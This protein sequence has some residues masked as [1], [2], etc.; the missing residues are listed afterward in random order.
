MLRLLTFGPLLAGLA[1]LCSSSPSLQAQELGDA[2]LDA[3]NIGRAGTSTVSGDSGVA[4]VQ[5]P[6]GMVRRAQSRLLLGVGIEDADLEYVST[7]ASSPTLTNRAAPTTLP[8]VAYHHGL[9]DGRWVLGVL[10]RSGSSTSSLPAPAFGQPADD[11]ERLF[12]H[13]YAGTA[14]ESTWRQLALGAA[15]RLGDSWGLG[16][17]VGLRDLEVREDRRIWAGFG[18]RDRLLGAERDLALS[19]VGRD[20]VNPSGSIGVL[21]APLAIPLEFAA[22]AEFQAGANLSSSSA[23][24]RSTNSSDF[25]RVE[26]NSASAQTSWNDRATLRGGMRY[27]GEQ[28]IVEAGIDM[29]LVQ[30]SSEELW[31]LTGLD[32]VDESTVR[33]SLT[34]APTLHSERSR[35][36][37]RGAVDY[38]AL[39]GF[40]WITGGYA[41]HAPST[42][43]NKRMP[44]YAKLGGHRLALGI[45]ANHE[46][47]SLSV[48]YSR[49][50]ARTR[51]IAD[52]DAQ[53]AI[54]PFEAGTG[55]ANA[56]SYRTASDQL[57]FS[58]EVAW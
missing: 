54:N 6:A 49:G 7:N 20:R 51:S 47:Y 50:F 53:Q 27:L 9:A 58:L 52:L 34:S 32:V 8:T 26:G 2:L 10:L 5:N 24:L 48:G 30:D 4:I 18:G 56:G 13:R 1:S 41:W 57:G 28:L 12:P 21:Y 42:S 35:M 39:A 40:L 37:I 25:P 19:I 14:Y 29:A 45:L 17:S 44:A 31:Q 43:Q 15:V 23:S 38:E 33:S 46:D 55:P 22:S 11:V 3:R 16:L 36:S